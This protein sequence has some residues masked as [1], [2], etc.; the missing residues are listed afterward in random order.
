VSVTDARAVLPGSA[1]ARRGARLSRFGGNATHLLVDR[2]T[3]TRRLDTLSTHR[4]V[5]SQQH[6]R[7]PRLQTRTDP[8]RLARA[9]AYNPVTNT[10]RRIAPL[11]AV[12]TGANAVW[13]G[14]EVL[15]VGGTGAPRGGNP[16]SLRPA[17][18]KPELRDGNRG[19][20]SRATP[21]SNSD[22]ERRNAT[23]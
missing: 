16:P 18:G 4:F 15:I 12:R 9:A 21:A 20:A 6:E 2:E 13:D 3:S 17:T 14:R 8:A 11:P 22:R 19:L 23:D 5:P 1:G 10:W 7:L